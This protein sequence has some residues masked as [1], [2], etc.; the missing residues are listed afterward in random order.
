MRKI[1]FKYLASNLTEVELTESGFSINEPFGA[2]PKLYNWNEIKNIRFSENKEEVIIG[3]AN[4]QIILKN[5]YTGW[6]EFIQNV[7]DKFVKFDFEYAKN[8]MESLK[9]CGVCGIVAVSGNECIVCESITW[10][11]E[12]NVNEVDYIKSKQLDLYSEKIKYKLEI[13]K[14]AEPEHG[15]NADKNWK[16]LI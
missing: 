4:K 14:I 13:K 11:K 3:K 7:P 8:F 12:M 2:K 16:L 6:Y 5:Y 15:F 1:F 10:N 9:P